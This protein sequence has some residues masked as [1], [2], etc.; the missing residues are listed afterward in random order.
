MLNQ[1]T[2]EMYTQPIQVLSGSS[3]GQHT[4]HILEF[5]IELKKGYKS[6][7]V[8]YDQRVRNHE[9]ETN[10]NTAGKNIQE[11]KLDLLKDDRDLLLISSFGHE[12]SLTQRVF[13]N[14]FRELVYNLEHSIHHMAI[15]RI[16]L[17]AIS[18]LIIPEEFGM[19]S[20]TLK[21]RRECAQ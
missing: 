6:G 19:A 14:Y 7:T 17:N 1:I 20:S 16:G 13:T 5:F 11:I 9:I 3:I 8:D 4:R 18:D 12:V 10:R 2:D 15:I 21:Y